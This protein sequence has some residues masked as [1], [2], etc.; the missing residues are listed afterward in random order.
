MRVE[1]C[2]RERDWYLPLPPFCQ[3][4]EKRLESPSSLTAGSTPGA[5][6]GQCWR[7]RTT[8]KKE[9]DQQIWWR[10]SSKPKSH[11]SLVWLK[12]VF[13]QCLGKMFL[14]NKTTNL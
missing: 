11:G 8:P 4:D 7:S 9:Q 14:K 13:L 1:G 2:E 5:G 6:E 10:S 3:K 12:G